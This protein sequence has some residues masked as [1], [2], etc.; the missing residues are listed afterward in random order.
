M[1][2]ISAT[3]L[4]FS[5][6]SVAAP[7]QLTVTGAST[8]EPFSFI[9]SNGE[10]DGIM[11][12]FWRL[13]GKK[14]NVDIQFQLMDWPASIAL[15][16]TDTSVI[17]GGLGY[18]SNRAKYLYFSREL[19]LQEYDVYL[20][21]K[22]EI[23]DVNL[24]HISDLNVGSVTA[25]VKDE[26]LTTRLPSEFIRRYDTFGA[27]NQAAY[28]GDIDV[29][30]DDLNTTKY[31]LY[32]NN[33]QG[34]FVPRRKLY[35]FSLHFAMSRQNTQRMA[36]IEKGLEKI[37]QE[38]VDAIY[39]KWFSDIP[40]IESQK[41][42]MW[43]HW[44]TYITS[45]MLVL[46]FI[47]VPIV[48]R[49][50]SEDLKS[51]LK[52]LAN[53]SERLEQVNQ[54]DRLTG[55]LNRDAFYNALNDKRFSSSPYSVAVLDLDNLGDL[56]AECGHQAGDMAI[57]HLISLLRGQLSSKAVIARLSGGEFA[58]LFDYCDKELAIKR[59]DKLRRSLP[60]TPLHLNQQIIRLS[61]C[62]SFAHYPVDGDEGSALV[63]CAL[64]KMRQLKAE[65]A[66]QEF[67]SAEQSRMASSDAELH[68]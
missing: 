16:S 42:S 30:I 45:L 28:R 59:I 20:F 65:K 67:A 66:K 47:A 55:T 5:T 8:W 49:R 6:L 26:F 54:I 58:V 51:A 62:Y 31:S 3:L 7:K 24:A 33:Q 37:S 35:S 68:W 29:F 2:L 43:P 63:T 14:N 22:R 1:S 32:K 50:K 34:T 27:M 15:A 36:E 48:L 11:V 39:D 41:P 61:F 19:P 38:E 40:G 18:T 12:D 56:N 17:H 64:K 52:A 13:Y 60:S 10:P 4:T 46:T 9:N 44:S 53:S 23:K 57:K 21:T 25:S